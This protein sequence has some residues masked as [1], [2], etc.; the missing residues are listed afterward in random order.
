MRKCHDQRRPQ[1]RQPRL[2]C[3]FP[4]GGTLNPDANGKH[5]DRVRVCSIHPLLLV[6]E[7]DEALLTVFSSWTSNGGGAQA[8][9]A[10]RGWGKMLPLHP[11]SSTHL[12]QMNRDAASPRISQ[13]NDYMNSP[14][15][16][17]P[18]LQRVSLITTKALGDIRKPGILP[19]SAELCI[20]RS[21]TSI[22]DPRTSRTAN[23]HSNPALAIT[24]ASAR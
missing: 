5:H 16:L 3:H 14:N 7:Q 19:P 1:S 23:C 8:R 22:S 6:Q 20:D 15:G 2:T 9:R 24:A 11:V 13:S 10:S 17:L 18:Q 12:L 21:T 4:V